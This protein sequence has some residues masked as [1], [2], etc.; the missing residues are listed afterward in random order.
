MPSLLQDE[1]DASEAKGE[2][3]KNNTRMFRHPMPEILREYPPLPL[4]SLLSRVLNPEAETAQP[5]V[6]A[7]DRGLIAHA[8]VATGNRPV[9]HGR[10]CDRR[11][12]SVSE[13]VLDTAYVLDPGARH[14]HGTRILDHF[15][16][17]KH[18]LTHS[19]SHSL[20]R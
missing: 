6:N 5:A 16:S 4:L 14:T 10:S 15:H 20:K 13:L 18:P 1:E 19:S 11:C 9:T 12:E 17:L 2:G 7:F 3:R 8:V